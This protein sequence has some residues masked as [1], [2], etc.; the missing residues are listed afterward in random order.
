ME[1]ILSAFHR[2]YDHLQSMYGSIIDPRERHAELIR[3]EADDVQAPTPFLPGTFASTLNRPEYEDAS[4]RQQQQPGKPKSTRLRASHSREEQQKRATRRLSNIYNH[5]TRRLSA[6]F[7]SSATSLPSSPDEKFS[8]FSPRRFSEPKLSLMGP[9]AS[10]TRSPLPCDEYYLV[11]DAYKSNT[12]KRSMVTYFYHTSNSSLGVDD[13]FSA[14]GDKVT[15]SAS[16]STSTSSSSSRCGGDD[17][18]YASG[19]STPIKPPMVH[20]DVSISESIQDA[21]TWQYSPLVHKYA[22]KA[23]E[24]ME[25]IAKCK[26][27]PAAT[28]LSVDWPKAWSFPMAL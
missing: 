19:T 22:I 6:V 18:A 17:S 24:E 1:T 8:T 16:T 12:H 2:Q 15:S 4:H 25:R 21:S 10:S 27:P 7:S 3:L 14:H 9:T 26:T 13:H 23:V 28:S 20:P 11:P 5:T